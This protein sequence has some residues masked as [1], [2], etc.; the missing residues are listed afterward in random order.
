MLLFA[1]QEII[2]QIEPLAKTIGINQGNCNSAA[3][4]LRINKKRKY[5]RTTIPLYIISFYWVNN[6]NE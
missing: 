5:K 2:H 6:N 4:D 3:F 1:K